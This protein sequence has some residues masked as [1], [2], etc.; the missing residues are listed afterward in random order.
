MMKKISSVAY[1]RDVEELAEYV[2]EERE[3]LLLDVQN[4]DIKPLEEFISDSLC[5]YFWCSSPN[6]CKK[7]IEYTKFF[8]AYRDFEQGDCEDPFIFIARCSMICDVKSVINSFESTTYE[9][10]DGRD[11]EMVDLDFEV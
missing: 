8:D 7:V 4:F 11:P 9:V 1:W 6:F 2:M 3:D 5:D 10:D